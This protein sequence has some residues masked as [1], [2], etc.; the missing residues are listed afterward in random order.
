M[1]ILEAVLVILS[2]SQQVI[3][4]G[5]LNRNV[6]ERAKNFIMDLVIFFDEAL[7]TCPSHLPNLE[8]ASNP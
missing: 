2:K 4:T 1:K 3:M 8:S 7:L 5:E 6:D